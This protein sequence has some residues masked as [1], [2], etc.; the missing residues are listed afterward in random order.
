[1]EENNAALHRLKHTNINIK[2]NANIQN[3][4]NNQEIRLAENLTDPINICEME[5]FIVDDPQGHVAPKPIPLATIDNTNYLCRS[6]RKG[7]VL[8]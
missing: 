8:L 4:I 6:N 2:D 5:V 1:M 7:Q 3:V